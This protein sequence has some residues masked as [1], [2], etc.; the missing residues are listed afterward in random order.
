M[1]HRENTKTFDLM[2]HHM[3]FWCG[4]RCKAFGDNYGCGCVWAVP[5]LSLQKKTTIVLI[6]GRTCKRRE[7]GCGQWITC[8]L[9]WPGDSQRESGRFTRIDSRES[10]RRKN[11]I[12]IT[13][14]QFAR[15]ASNLRFAILPPPKRDSQ[16]YGGSIQEP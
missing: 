8:P 16:F 11:P 4:I 15:I 6:R 7:R 10:I 13:C 1:E 9:R 2:C 3:P 5:D 12:F 14:E